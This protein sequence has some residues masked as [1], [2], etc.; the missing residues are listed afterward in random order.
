MGISSVQYN[1]A[2]A[3]TVAYLSNNTAGNLLILVGRTNTPASVTVSDSQSNAW[4]KA[5]AQANASTNGI[6]IWYAPNCKAGANTVTVSGGLG[7]ELV[8][9]EYSGLA[10][11]GVLD[12]GITNSG[13]GSGN[14]YS[15]GSI[16]PSK[17][18]V[19]MIGGVENDTANG[20][21]DT[22]TGGFTDRANSLGNVFLADQIVS[23]LGTYAYGGSYSNP[24]VTWAAGVVSFLAPIAATPTF[25]PVAGTYT[26]TQTVTITSASAGT[27]IYYTTDGSTP[28]HASS[29]IANGGTISVATSE[30][31]KAIAYSTGFND[32]AVGSAAYTINTTPVSGG[33]GWMNALHD[34][35]NKKGLRG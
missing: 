3:S 17:N 24:A 26:G 28:T 8:I 10:T 9:A 34:F 19:L 7:V 14:P 13:S 5:V 27:T 18:N 23:S 35:A 21:T 33:G 31:V 29:S 6:V 1:S 4:A 22:P 25:S 15:G 12:P 16:T 20:L 11:S 32:S 2:V 30:T